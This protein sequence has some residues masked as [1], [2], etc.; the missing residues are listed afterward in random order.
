VVKDTAASPRWRNADISAD[1]RIGGVLYAQHQLYV[2]PET[3]S[4]IGGLIVA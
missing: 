1:D 4:G 2:N 3:V